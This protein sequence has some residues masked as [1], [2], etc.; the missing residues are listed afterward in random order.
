LNKDTIHFSLMTLSHFQGVRQIS[1][2]H[3]SVQCLELMEACN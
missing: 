2:I 3:G 1:E